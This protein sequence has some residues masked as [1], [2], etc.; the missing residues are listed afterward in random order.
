MAIDLA[1]VSDERRADARPAPSLREVKTK[2]KRSFASAEIPFFGSSNRVTRDDLSLFTNQ[3]T[4][5]LESGN[6]LVPSMAALAKQTK[7]RGL[8]RVLEDIHLRLEE[9]SVLSDCLTR[10]PKVF[11]ELFVGLIR[12]GEASG[13]LAESLTC[14]TGILE[15][16]GRMARHIREAMT[17]PVVISLVMAGVLVFLFTYMLPKFSVL[18]ANLGDELPVTTRVLLGSADFLASSWKWLLPIPF[19]AAFLVRKLWNLEPF[20]RVRDRLKLGIPILSS[21]FRDGYLFQLF[22]SMGLLLRSRV[23]LLEAIQITRD[24]VRNYWYRVFFDRLVENVEAGRGMTHAFSEA[25]F[26]PETVKLMIST[27]EAA[28]TLDAVM[29]KLSEKY[30]D[31]LESN[32]R[33]LSSALEPVM[34]I[35][36]GLLVGMIAMSI[37]LPLFKLS[38]AM[39]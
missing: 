28:G 19:V 36:M 35:V 10:H 22:L 11:D 24:T 13:A 33:R 4:L 21:F 23:P 17:Y 1:K 5:L 26:L 18:F 31:D 38:R 2:P 7:S 14:L 34:L 39:H 30:R 3:L 16:R 37:I 29:V 9:G 15:T 12:A 8:Q 6:T 25:S 20:Q 27:G 32:I